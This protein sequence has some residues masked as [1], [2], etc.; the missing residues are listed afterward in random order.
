MRLTD[1]LALARRGSRRGYQAAVVL[2]TAAAFT[3]LCF[4]AAIFM[5]NRSEKSQPCELAVTAPGYL[6]LTEQTVQDFRA[7]PQVVDASGIVEA[8]VQ[9]TTG[10]YAAGLALVGIDGDYLHDLVYTTGEPFPESGAMPW[11]VLSEG[12]AKTFADPEDETKHTASYMPDIDWLGAD[13]TLHVGGSAVAAR[14]SGV[15]EGNGP[16]AYVRLDSLRALLQSLGQPSGYTGVRVRVTSIGA[17]EAVSRAITDLGYQVENRD[18]ARQD[19]WDARSREAVYLAV[20]AAA[21]IL[22]ACLVTVAGAARSREA[23]RRRAD[24]LRWAG[25]SDATIRG[26]GLLRGA[27]LALLGAVLGIG[28]HALTAALVALADPASNFAL[29]IW[30]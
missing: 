4:S 2:F 14:V 11:L 15:F 9:I 29:T 17:A 30:G 8:S 10:K 23:D 16:A 12:A 28:V 1:Y 21:G 25:M 18:S 24:V 27:Y 7:I 6:S 19:K 3:A 26:L 5:T 20:L 22:C 13:F